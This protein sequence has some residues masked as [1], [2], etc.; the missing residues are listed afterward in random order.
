LTIAD[1]DNA[2]HDY[3]APQADI[4]YRSGL[5]SDDVLRLYEESRGSIQKVWQN[6]V[7]HFARDRIPLSQ[8]AHDFL[9]DRKV[10]T[11]DLSYFDDP[12]YFILREI[13]TRLREVIHRRFRDQDLSNGLVVLD[14]AHLFA[15]QDAERE[16]DVGQVLNYLISSVRMMRKVGVGWMFITNSLT[17]F[18]K[19][20]YKQLR[21]R[22][23]AQGLTSGAERE[24]IREMVGDDALAIYE[25]LPDPDQSGVFSFMIWGAI[26]AL[27]TRGAPLFITGFSGEDEVIRYN[28]HVF[29]P[30]RS[31]GG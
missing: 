28:S 9:V 31:T 10:V 24:H 23:F 1:L 8:I 4:V 13:L 6:T 16:S 18:N 19:E 14:E 27:G 15:P 25:D 3:L 7:A 11:L 21:V 30:P 2:V 12:P 17:D 26:L 22:I 29:R 5:R 20:I